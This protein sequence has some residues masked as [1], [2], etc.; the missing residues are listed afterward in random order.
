V[1]IAGD[2]NDFSVEL[3]T[4]ESSDTLIRLGTLTSLFG[5]GILFLK[6]MKSKELLDKVESDFWRFVEEACKI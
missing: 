5:G 6:G 1:R 2:P 4:E 3:S